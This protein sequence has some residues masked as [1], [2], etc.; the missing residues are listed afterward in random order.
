MARA[1]TIDLCFEYATS[2]VDVDDVT[3]AGEDYWTDNDPKKARGIYYH[4]EK[5]AQEWW[6]VAGD[7]F[8][9]T[10]IGCT[11]D[12]TPNIANGSYDIDIYS[13][14][15]VQDNWIYAEDAGT[16]S[17]V[18]H[19]FVY[20]HTAGSGQHPVLAVTVGTGNEAEFNVYQAMAY[21]L[22]RHAGGM[23]E[24]YRAHVGGAGDCYYD[25]AGAEEPIVIRS[26]CDDWKFIIVHELAHR[27]WHLGSGKDEEYACSSYQGSRCPHTSGNHS[28][29]SQEVSKCAVAEGFAHFYAADVFNNHNEASCKLEYW[30]S[31]GGDGTPAVD[32]AWGHDN[33]AAAYM[34][35]GWRG[36]PYNGYGCY[37]SN[38]PGTAVELDYFRT[39]WDMHTSAGSIGFTTIFEWIAAADNWGNEY[40]Y[41]ELDEEADQIGGSLDAAWDKAKSW[42]GIVHPEP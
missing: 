28:M 2:F 39:F 9:G 31:V 16:S 24:E 7:G 30:D 5:G 11:G 42:N 23:E 33:F 15:R 32:C 14:G 21:A 13:V 38:F 34:E 18:T 26:N 3:D 37:A 22:Y 1:D 19:S 40:A 41:N 8:G 36:S 20:N 10:D 35:S 29:L 4:I 12:K 17:Y 27:M 25:P 6:G